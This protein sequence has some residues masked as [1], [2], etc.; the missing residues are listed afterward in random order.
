[1]EDWRRVREAETGVSREDREVIPEETPEETPEE[2]QRDQPEMLEDS[3]G[4]RFLPGSQ[5]PVEVV[6]GL[7]E[8]PAG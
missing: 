2:P 3:E 8:I 4:G 1:M 6:E 5:S 7:E